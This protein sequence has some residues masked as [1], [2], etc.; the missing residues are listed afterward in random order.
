MY[1]LN[2]CIHSYLQSGLLEKQCKE[3]ELSFVCVFGAHNTVISKHLAYP[4]L[5][6]G[7][8]QTLDCCTVSCGRHW[9]LFRHLQ[10]YNNLYHVLVHGFSKIACILI[11]LRT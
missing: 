9:V 11:E 5:A 6:L 2:A 10:K 7:M 8:L 3:I 1:V 4:E